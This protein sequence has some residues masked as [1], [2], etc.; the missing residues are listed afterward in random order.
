MAFQQRENS[1]TL[2]RND[3]GDNPK[4]PDYKG[5]MNVGGVLYEIVGWT[6]DGSKGKFLSLSIKPKEDRKPAPKKPAPAKS[7]D[8]FEDD[9][10]DTIPFN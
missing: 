7:P 10:D 3:K 6:K 5:D 2:F 4:R 8:I 1:G 9:P